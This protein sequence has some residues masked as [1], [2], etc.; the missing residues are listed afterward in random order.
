MIKM[1]KKI[2]LNLII[3]VSLFVF[4]STVF[5]QAQQVE[6]KNP[7]GST[8]TFPALLG[9]ISTAV[10]GLIGILGVI[11][12]IVSGVLFVTSAGSPDRVGAAKKALTYAVIGIAVGIAAQ[13][14]INTLK[15]VLG[16]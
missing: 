6:I 13:V 11:M 5:A 7:L 9:N 4:T 12:L 3:F 1:S 2:F 16:V 15:W 10:A 14:I 8:S